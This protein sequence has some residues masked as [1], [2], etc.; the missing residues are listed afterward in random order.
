[1]SAITRPL[2][3]PAS[4]L[5]PF[6]VRRELHAVAD[7]V[8]ACFADALD[9]DG[10]R[11]VEQMH[12]AARNPSYLRWA[13]NVADHVSMALSGYVWEENGGLAGHL[14]LIPFTLLGQKRYLIAN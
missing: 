9:E 11:Y 12:T 7:L 4:H 3:P 1:M 2:T 6:A 14:S 8:Q 10:Q 13:A 5:R